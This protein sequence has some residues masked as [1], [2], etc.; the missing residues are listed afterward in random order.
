MKKTEERYI[1]K[2][3]NEK[4]IVRIGNTYYKRC[5]SKNE[6]IQ[7]R[8]QVV[9]KNLL[10]KPTIFKTKTDKKK[11]F[12]KKIPI[13][14]ELLD[15]PVDTIVK[16][17]D[18]YLISNDNFSYEYY[19][20]QNGTQPSLNLFVENNNNLKMENANLNYITNCFT[21]HSEMKN[22]QENEHENWENEILKHMSNQF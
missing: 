16:T 18:L 6:A 19:H 10:T 12:P 15:L 21:K 8:D 13:E 20:K 11:K 9:I 22:D 1:Y 5:D 4:W 3:P 2:T 17:W 7:I 14:L